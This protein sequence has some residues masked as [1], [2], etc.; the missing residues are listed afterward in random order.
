V[1][2]IALTAALASGGGMPAQE[3][4]REALEDLKREVAHLRREQQEHQAN[5][6]KRQIAQ[7]RQEGLEQQLDAMRR[8]IEGLRYGRAVEVPRYGRVIEV[9]RYGRAVLP[10]RTE[11]LPAL[12]QGDRATIM[13]TIPAGARVSVDGRSIPVDSRT[14]VFVTPPLDAGKSYYYVL[15]VTAPLTGNLVEKKVKRID[16]RPGSVV[17]I[18]YADMLVEKGKDLEKGDD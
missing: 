3:G 10:L 1:Y 9:P 17:R 7:I 18:N 13:L 14:P 5:E 16:F 4:I 11:S 12:S 6:L 8:E 15:A 2:S